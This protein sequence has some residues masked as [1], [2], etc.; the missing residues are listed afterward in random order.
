MSSTQVKIW[1][2]LLLALVA[3]YGGYSLWRINRLRAE[4]QVTLTP[5]VSDRP[6]EPFT[7]TDRSGDEFDS[8]SLQGQVWVA[9]FFFSTCPGSCLKMN[10]SIAGL[11]EEFGPLGVT[12]VS[13]TVDP[14]NDTPDRLKEYSLH[15]KARPEHW[16]FL[17]GDVADLKHVANDLFLLPFDKA[18]HSDR[19]MLVGPDGRVRARF[20]GT[21]PTQVAQL[22]KKLK[23]LLAEVQEPAAE[24]EATAA[25]ATKSTND[26][27]VAP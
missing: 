21:D 14:E 26:A 5:T 13:I 11:Q 18:A 3:A 24:G 27:E 2:G 9:S 20:S 25:T 15:Y 8:A 23:S 17:T 10:N 4:Q 1:M 19:L 7:L 22:K 16:R 6:L 12:F